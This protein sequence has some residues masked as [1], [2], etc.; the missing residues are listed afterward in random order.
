MSYLPSLSCKHTDFIW[1]WENRVCLEE[2]CILSL[3]NFLL[4][5]KKAVSFSFIHATC[6]YLNSSCVLDSCLGVGDKLL[7]KE[8][9]LTQICNVVFIL[10]CKLHE[11]RE[12]FF[13]LL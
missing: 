2:Y 11:S 3:N 4:G 13:I 6:I 1:G 10:E 5:L 7:H 9:V 8:K 12:F